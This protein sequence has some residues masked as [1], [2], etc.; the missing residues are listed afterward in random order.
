MILDNKWFRIAGTAVVAAVAFTWIG[1]GFR[2]SFEPWQVGVVAVAA[3]L[4]AW[5]RNRGK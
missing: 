5:Y 4:G 2:M 3:A 1:N